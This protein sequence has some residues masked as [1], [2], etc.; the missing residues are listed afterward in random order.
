MLIF[1]YFL[2]Q[3]TYNLIIRNLQI[4]V[5]MPFNFTRFRII[6]MT[7]FHFLFN[8]IYIFY[9]IILNYFHRRGTFFSLSLLIVTSPQ[10]K[11]TLVRLKSKSVEILSTPNQ[12]WLILNRWEIFS[13]TIYYRDFYNLWTKLT[14]FLKRLAIFQSRGESSILRAQWW[15]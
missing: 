14:S 5:T 13:E 4:K 7:L 11:M 10:W 8:S 3:I 15:T 2:L 1:L 12:K 6:R 9:I